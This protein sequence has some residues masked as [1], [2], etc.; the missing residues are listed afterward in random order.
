MQI[1]KLKKISTDRYEVV[2]E[3]GEKVKFYSDLILKS[4][5]LYQKEISDKT[6]EFL[7]QENQK[8]EIYHQLVKFLSKTE[9]SEQEAREYLEKKQCSNIDEIIE[10]VK[11]QKL[12][13]NDRFLKAYCHDHMYL[14]SDGPEKIIKDVIKKGIEESIVRQ[15]LSTYASFFKEKQNRLLEKKIKGN[16]KDTVSMMKQ[17]LLYEFIN[18]G[19]LKEDIIEYLDT[20]SMTNQHIEEDYEKIKQKWQKKYQGKQLEQKIKEKLYQKGYSYEE[21]LSLFS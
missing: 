8:L 3:N 14:S 21:I 4:S 12:L 10:K 20:I 2:F 17:K 16:H 6:L 15:Y 19:Y 9:K 5:F 18:K 13:D 11:K 1:E 7:K